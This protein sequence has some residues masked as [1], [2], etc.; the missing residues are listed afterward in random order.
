[1]MEDSVAIF[2]CIHGYVKLFGNVYEY[3]GTIIRRIW[4]AC[5]HTNRIQ[6]M[7]LR[8]HAHVL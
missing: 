5:M 2:F 4:I 8:E 1:M 6:H 3:V 7:R